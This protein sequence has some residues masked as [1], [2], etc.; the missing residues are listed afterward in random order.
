MPS[1]NLLKVP[2]TSVELGAVAALTA[3]FG[4]VVLAA[5]DGAGFAV[6]V[7]RCG[8]GDGLVVAVLVVAGLVVVLRGFG[9]VVDEFVFCASATQEVASITTTVRTVLRIMVYSSLS[10]SCM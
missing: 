7:A 4:F 2:T 1:S 9:V 8:V 6:S 5:G 10:K 3:G